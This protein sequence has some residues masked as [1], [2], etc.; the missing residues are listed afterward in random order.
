MTAEPY[1]VPLDH[2][3]EPGNQ[4]VVRGAL[5]G[6]SFN[7]NL[8]T[9][10]D[11]VWQKNSGDDIAL[12]ITYSRGSRNIILNSFENGH[13]QREEQFNGSLIREQALFEIRVLVQS[14]RY[15]IFIDNIKLADFQHRIHF[16]TVKFVYVVGDI[17]LQL[18]D[19]GNRAGSRQTR[20]ARPHALEKIN[21]AS[22]TP[23]NTIVVRGMPKGAK[24]D[25]NLSVGPDM[26]WE[27]PTGDNV[28]LHV[29]YSGGARRLILNSY[30]NGHWGPE[31]QYDAASIRDGATFEIRIQ[32]DQGRFGIF[33]D[34]Q[35]LGDFNFRLPLEQVEYVYVVGDIDLESLNVGGTSEGGAGSGGTNGFQQDGS[36]GPTVP[37]VPQPSL[38]IPYRQ[39]L[40]KSIQVGQKLVIV[41]TPNSNAIRFHVNLYAGH[42]NAFHQMVNFQEKS[43]TRDSRTKGEDWDHQVQTDTKSGFPYEPG[44]Q[45]R[46]V[47]VVEDGA[48]QIFVDDSP[49]FAYE[50]RLPLAKING[51]SIEGDIQLHTVKFE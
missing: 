4:I 15:E 6:G 13:W 22:L 12:H 44:R 23:G 43:V 18:V 10:S 3:L 2:P 31:E 37:T 34:G 24:F 47:Y 16:Q 49:Q 25:I 5:V 30:E 38:P 9:G 27:K 33:L 21:P 35:K 36:T 7:I 26:L 51:L 17:H 40:Q 50:H 39:K 19:V 32:I 29:S 48:F 11:P 46:L 41:G 42:L 45:F 14:D 1:F 28:A 20:Q 8:S